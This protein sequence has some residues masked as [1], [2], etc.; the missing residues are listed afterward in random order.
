LNPVKK[1]SSIKSDTLDLSQGLF[2]KNIYINGV[3]KFYYY[4]RQQSPESKIQNINC[5][6]SLSNLIGEKNDAA[7]SAFY[8]H[9]FSYF[10]YPFNK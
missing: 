8:Q 7:Y 1:L 9:N 3:K 4:L 10:L 5:N 6:T 2:K